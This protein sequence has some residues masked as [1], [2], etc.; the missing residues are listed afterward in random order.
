M[1]RQPSLARFLRSPDGGGAAAPASPGAAPAAGAPAGGAA[2]G[3]GAPP[4]GDL[5]GILGA[6]TPDLRGLI[7]TKGWHKDAQGP[8]QLLERVAKG[9]A[10]LERTVGLDKIALPPAGADGKRDWSKAD[11]VFK[12][13]GRPDK[14]EYD[15]LKA[16]DGMSEADKATRTRLATAVH[17]AGLAPWQVEIVAQELA[18]MNGEQ[19]GATDAEVTAQTQATE[20]ALKGKWGAA[21]DAKMHAANTAISRMG[22]GMVDKIDKSGLGRDAQFIEFM[23]GI[24]AFFLEDG[25]TPPGGGGG[26]NGATL[27][28]AQAQA[29]L[30]QMYAN[31]A[32]LAALQDKSHPEY[33]ALNAKK[34]RLNA[35]IYPE[36]GA[37]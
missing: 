13:L 26:S 2:P 34:L 33:A 18:A 23:A 1:Y 14:P 4:A 5:A 37:G 20:T 35:M 3:G 15:V 10:D 19:A 21:F 25:T 8:H 7:E 27:T 22:E 30:D 36:Q 32:T 24:G 9:Y 31:P 6:V 16:A 17:K 28:P 12:A 29:E 11:Q